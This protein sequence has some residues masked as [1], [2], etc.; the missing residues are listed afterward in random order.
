MKFINKIAILEKKNETDKKITDILDFMKYEY[1]YEY[2]YKKNNQKIYD[3]I[4][5]DNCKVDSNTINNILLANQHQQYIVFTEK[6]DLIKNTSNLFLIN[7]KKNLKKELIKNIN[8]C[9]SKTERNKEEYDIEKI[10]IGKTPVIKKVKKLVKKVSKTDTNVLILGESGTG[11]ELVAQSIHKL[12]RRNKEKLITINCGAIPKELLES[13]LFGHEKGS[14]TGAVSSRKGK[15][16]EA[17]KGTIFLDEIGDMPLSMQVKLLRILQEMT[18]EKIGSNRLFNIDVRVIAA[19]HRNLEKMIEQGLF[20]EDLFYR[21]NVF[22]ITIPPL[23]ERV[24]DIKLIINKICK[25]L[26]QKNNKNITLTEDAIELL[27]SKRWKGNIRELKNLIERL[28][29][30][31]DDTTI[32]SEKI[33]KNEI[34]IKTIEQKHLHEDQSKKQNQ[35]KTIKKEKNTLG[36]NEEK[37]LRENLADIEIN[38][39]KKALDKSNGVVSKAAKKLKVQRTTL[40]EK[41]KKYKI[42]IQEFSMD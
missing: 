2:N 38:M 19:T 8:L 18:V 42:N 33:I 32:D 22:P 26:V 6:S 9:K 11:K 15:F 1:D 25:D 4:I 17:H 24:P 13:E 31:Y 29:V 10:I 41:I 16:E 30:I 40:I 37:S 27:S 36:I 34:S 35:I 23:N 7:N 39:I 20:R 21:L 12:S 5:V 3:A 14:F 28:S